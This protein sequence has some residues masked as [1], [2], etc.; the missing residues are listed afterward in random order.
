MCLS[1]VVLPLRVLPIRHIEAPPVFWSGK[2]ISSS[3][4][5]MSVIFI[6]H[7]FNITTIQYGFI[8]Y[9]SAEQSCTG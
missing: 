2:S 6:L 9:D 8:A 7:G 1:S 5:T 4:V 3:F